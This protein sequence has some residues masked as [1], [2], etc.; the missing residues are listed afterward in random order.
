MQ[1]LLHQL[2]ANSMPIAPLRGQMVVD[3]LSAPAETHYNI[4]YLDGPYE[5]A[6]YSTNASILPIISGTVNLLKHPQK[7]EMLTKRS[8]NT[9][10]SG[11]S[12]LNR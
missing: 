8:N 5:L 11:G 10:S 6:L 1:P 4:E 3:L 7:L 12:I 2:E 9:E